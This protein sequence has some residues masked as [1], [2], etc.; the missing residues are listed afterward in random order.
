MTMPSCGE[1]FD[2]ERPQQ[3]Q[4]QQQQSLHSAPPCP[5]LTPLP[6]PRDQTDP[7]LSTINRLEDAVEARSLDAA[8]DA[9]TTLSTAE[10]PTPDKHPE[11]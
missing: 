10:G 11:K 9:L 4:Q 8:I 7:I 3:Q 1:V 6:N 5:R 2:Y